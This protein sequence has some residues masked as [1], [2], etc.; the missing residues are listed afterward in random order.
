M[1][2]SVRR[3]DVSARVTD[4]LAN[5]RTFLAWIRT[6]LALVAFGFF[7]GRIGVY[8]QQGETPTDIPARQRSLFEHEFVV[9]GV[10]CLI[11]GTVISAWAGWQYRRNRI[12][13]EHNVFEPATWSVTAMAT[14]SVAGGIAIIALVLSGLASR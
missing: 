13:I 8:F 4:H 12:A 3:T 2:D 10:V 7:L 9:M 14:I 11:L 1:N 6:A 5:E